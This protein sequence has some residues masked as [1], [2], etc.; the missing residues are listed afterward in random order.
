M[1]SSSSNLLK[2]IESAPEL[3]SLRNS[4]EQNNLTGN[5]QEPLS[6]LS[7]LEEDRNSNIKVAEEKNG[8][9]EGVFCSEVVF[10]LSKKNLSSL[11]ID[12]LG[13]ELRFVPT[14]TSKP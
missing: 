9:L 4:Q 7:N 5:D 6:T 10:N 14:L 2:S 13:K 11:E 12:V 8:R 3:P 1:N